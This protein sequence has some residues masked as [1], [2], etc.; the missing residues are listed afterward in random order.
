MKLLSCFALAV[1]LMAPVVEARTAIV[2]SGTSLTNGY[3][4]DATPYPARLATAAGVNAINFGVN[5]D[6]LANIV[7]RWRNYA[8]V[9]PYRVLVAEGG[10][11][12]LAFD[13]ADGVTLWGTFEDW[14][15]EAQA[16]GFTVVLVLIPPRSDVAWTGDMETQRLAFN[17]AGRAYQGTHPSVL[18]IDSDVLLG[19]GG[20]PVELN[21]LYRCVDELHLCAAGMQVLANAIADL[22]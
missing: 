12:D 14:I 20:T 1:L 4:Y 5:G 17:A 19:D 13:A 11:N 6:R 16:A 10:T 15:E 9:F 2:C 18:M 7:L 3:V 8:K 21:P 22:L